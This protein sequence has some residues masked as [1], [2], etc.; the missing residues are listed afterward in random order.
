MQ[1]TEIM[2]SSS[3]ASNE[4]TQIIHSMGFRFRCFINMGLFH[5]MD[6]KR[7]TSLSFSLLLFK[8]RFSKRILKRHILDFPY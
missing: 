4:V 3:L 7:A 8:N 6:G 1:V 2:L 5:L